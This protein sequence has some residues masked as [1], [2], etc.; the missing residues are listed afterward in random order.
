[1]PVR[2]GPADLMRIAL[3]RCPLPLSSG[4]LT[5]LPQQPL[6]RG[7]GFGAELSGFGVMTLG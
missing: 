5:L 4:H 1:M 7:V 6:E 3:L 2:L